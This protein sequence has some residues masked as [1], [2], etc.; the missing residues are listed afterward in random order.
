MTLTLNTK[1]HYGA[2]KLS[3]AEISVFFK[4]IKLKTF[5]NNFNN[6]SEVVLVEWSNRSI[7]LGCRIVTHGEIGL[8]YNQ[9]KE[10][11]GLKSLSSAQSAH[12]RFLNTN[13]FSTKTAPA[14][15]EKLS[16]KDEALNIRRLS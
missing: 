12:K 3:T 9:I 16:E 4:V 15:P 6:L 8:S 7:I 11:L 1:I 2:K 14:K 5:M 10:N 13:S